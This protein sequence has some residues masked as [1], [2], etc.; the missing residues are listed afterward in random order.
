MSEVIK[1]PDKRRLRGEQSRRLILQAV[2]DSI[3]LEGL[4]RFTLDRVAERVGISRGL[5][6]FHF[7]SK[8]N[9]IEEVL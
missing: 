7:K 2:I 5:V 9:L 4:G 8:K 6:V 3:A 1:T